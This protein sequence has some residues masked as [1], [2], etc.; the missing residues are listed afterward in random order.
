M[1]MCTIQVISPGDT[2]YRETQDMKII[3]TCD[4][5]SRRPVDICHRKEILTPYLLVRLIS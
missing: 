2:K 1:V 5:T 4:V 3:V